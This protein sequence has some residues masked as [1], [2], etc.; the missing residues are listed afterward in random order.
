MTKIADTQF[1]AINLKTALLVSAIA[2]GDLVPVYD[3]TSNAWKV[4]DVNDLGSD[5]E[6]AAAVL[7]ANGATTAA[8]IGLLDLSAQTETILVTGAI[9]ITKRCT[10]LSAASGAYAVTLAAPDA[11]MLGQVKVIQMTV[12]GNALT[13]ALT[14]VQ[15]GSA[16]TTASFDAVNETLVLLAGASKWTVLKEVG[17]TLS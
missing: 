2:A 13:L 6:V 10:N 3:A 7:A 12:A 11:T 16:G 8:E 9:S 4:I 5:A 1:T 14:N 17:V 15:G